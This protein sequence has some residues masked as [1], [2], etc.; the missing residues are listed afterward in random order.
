MCVF[1]IIDQHK[2]AEFS[3]V[4]V[5]TH[6]LL[7]ADQPASIST[8]TSLLLPA[9]YGRGISITTRQLNRL[10]DLPRANQE[11]GRKQQDRLQRKRKCLNCLYADDSC[12][13]ERGGFGSLHNGNPADSAH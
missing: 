11:V 6:N 7:S 8:F 5:Q 10:P 9:H 13:F 12:E 2:K 1:T 4:H 3:A